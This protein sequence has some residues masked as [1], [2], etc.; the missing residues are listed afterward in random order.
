MSAVD[1]AHARS[2]IFYEVNSSRV[3][4]GFVIAVFVIL[5]I[6]REVL[7]VVTPLDLIPEVAFRVSAVLAVAVVVIDAWF[8]SVSGMIDDPGWPGWFWTVRAAV[9]HSR[10]VC[11]NR[12]KPITCRHHCSGNQ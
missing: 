7:A 11:W 1:I 10:T 4:V 2:W 6:R 12:G 3:S 5:V 8:L 9:F